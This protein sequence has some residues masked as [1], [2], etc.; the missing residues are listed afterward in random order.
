MRDTCG[1]YQHRDW[2]RSAPLVNRETAFI[3]AVSGLLDGAIQAARND[4]SQG[5][6]LQDPIKTSK[7]YLQTE[8]PSQRPKGI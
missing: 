2:Q 1:F 5:E 8:K 7:N 6:V 3:S 4:G